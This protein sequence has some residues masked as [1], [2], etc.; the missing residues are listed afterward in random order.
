MTVTFGRGDPL[1]TEVAAGA[2]APALLELGPSQ[3][4]V[5]SQAQSMSSQ[6]SGCQS[7]SYDTVTSIW[8]DCAS[9]SVLIK[10]Y[11]MHRTLP[12]GYLSRR[13][14][15]L[16]CLTFC[17]YAL[18]STVCACAMPVDLGCAYPALLLVQ[19]RGAR[20]TDMVLVGSATDML[21]THILHW[22]ARRL[23]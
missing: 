15:P 5:T 20:R 1:F 16:S 8:S 17:V 10:G 14:L 11:R 6:R 18:L 9:A 21:K 22:Q 19:Q 7:S 3:E 4:L 2:A 12:S 23:V 13:S